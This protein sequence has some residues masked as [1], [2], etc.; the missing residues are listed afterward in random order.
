ML[1]N[2]STRYEKRTRAVP[3]K[4]SQREED[5]LRAE[6]KRQGTSISELIRLGYI[7]KFENLMKVMEIKK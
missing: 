1:N 3:I 4:V 2:Y 5:F 7:N 6:A